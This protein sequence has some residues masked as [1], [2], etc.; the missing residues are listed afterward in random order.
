MKKDTSTHAWLRY[1]SNETLDLIRS[2]LKS[3]SYS[4]GESVHE[5]GAIA[6]GL[7]CIDEGSVRFG[8]LNN[9]GKELIVRDLGKGEWFGFIGCFGSGNRPNNAHSIADTRLSFLGMSDIE[10]IARREPLIWRGIA[11]LMAHYVEYFYKTYEDAIFLPLVKRL[12]STIMQLCEWQ[13]S[14]QLMIS[15]SELASILGVTKEAVGI[16][17]NVL[18]TQGL[19]KLGYRSI[20]YTP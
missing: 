19:V 6:G 2:R 15:Q 8:A 12:E 1:C 4:A 11:E 3:L 9:E 17:L 18:Q 14:H 7:Y 16:N 5:S 20:L 13:D 10:S